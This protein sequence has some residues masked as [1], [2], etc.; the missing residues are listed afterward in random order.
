[1]TARTDSSLR[2]LERGPFLLAMTGSAAGAQAAE[3]E[4]DR[5]LGDQPDPST[6]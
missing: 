6:S 1:V 3:D 5:R 4:A 2:A